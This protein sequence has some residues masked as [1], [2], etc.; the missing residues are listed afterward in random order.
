MRVVQRI[1]TVSDMSNTNPLLRRDKN[2]VE[3]RRVSIS[4]VPEEVKRV[5]VELAARA[6]DGVVHTHCAFDGAVS[7]V[8]VYACTRTRLDS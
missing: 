4:F 7:A 3:P 5:G 2:F 8:R 6:W 1:A